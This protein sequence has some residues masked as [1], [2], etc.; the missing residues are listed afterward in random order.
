MAQYWDFPVRRKIR[1]CFSYPASDVGPVPNGGARI[2]PD[3]I[4]GGLLEADSAEAGKAEGNTA[5]NER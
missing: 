1:H 4:V 2:S 3:V 5:L